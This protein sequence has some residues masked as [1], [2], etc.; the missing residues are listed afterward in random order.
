M[1]LFNKIYNFI[2]NKRLFFSRILVRLTNII[3]PSY[4]FL[5]RSLIL[6]SKKKLI[7]KEA[8]Y[9][10]SLTSF[11]ARIYKSWIPIETIMRQKIKPRKVLL[12]LFEG[13]FNGK[14]S[15]PKSLLR[16]EK[17]GLEIRFCKENLMPH[18]KYFYTMLEYPDAIV[19]TVDDDMFYPPDLCE[20]LIKFHSKYPDSIICSMTRQI[21][22]KDDKILPYREWS[23][24]RS[25][26]E[27]DFR[28]LTMGVSGTLFPPKSLHP[29]VF[30]IEIL[31]KIAL[32]ADDLW[33]KIMSIKNNTKVAS[34]A[35]EY[36]GFFI[37]IIYKNDVKLMESN[38]VG[39]QND[40]IFND[41][42]EYYQIPV[43]IFSEQNKQ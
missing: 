40:K 42:M 17:R 31:K 26:S 32:K 34:I 29:E 7:E 20:K 5:T 23:Y 21:K 10:V 43:S 30:N 1:L 11:P 16:L 15:L 19:I 22:V 38:I 39:G 14:A 8:N 28:N 35:G 2:F 12:W 25:N 37:P 33:L 4:F 3:L 6:K 27:P 13:E 24:L 36:P 41:L 9:I 18:K